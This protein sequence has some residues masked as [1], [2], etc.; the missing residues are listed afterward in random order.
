MR[1]CSRSPLAAE[2]SF[3]ALDEGGGRSTLSPPL[4]L[5]AAGGAAR[6]GAVTCGR[7]AG[8]V[9]AVAACAMVAQLSSSARR[10][11]FTSF[12]MPLATRGASFDLVHSITDL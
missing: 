9:R 2:Y 3:C 1:I 4:S 8:A 10:T 5:A 7:G 11:G 6:G 12:I